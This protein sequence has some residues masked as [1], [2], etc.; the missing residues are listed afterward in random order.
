MLQRILLVRHGHTAFSTAKIVTGTLDPPL[1]DVGKSES[2]RVGER[3]ATYLG[4]GEVVICSSDLLRCLE[5]SACI[6][7]ALGVSGDPIL[8]PEMRE[9][10]WGEAQGKPASEVARNPEL[11]AGAESNAAFAARCLEGVRRGARIA[12]SA[13][14][15]CVLVCSA[16]NLGVVRSALGLPVVSTPPNTVLGLLAG[17]NGRMVRMTEGGDPSWWV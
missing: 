13:G 11:A 7:S 15:S 9:K 1:S 2:K 17:V 4:Q 5:T 16:G 8:V 14:K 10:F 12:Q 3:L 6:A